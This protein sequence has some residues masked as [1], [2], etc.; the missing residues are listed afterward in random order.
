MIYSKIK[1]I[2]IALILS[3]SL[4]QKFSY[5]SSSFKESGRDI[6]NPGQ[7]FYKAVIVYFDS[8]S[9]QYSLD[10]ADQVYH[11]RCELSLYS[12]A[13]NHVSDKE[14]S[15]GA[16][17]GLD[18]L[19]SKIKSENKNA[20]IRFAYDKGLIGNTNHE[21]SM[22]TIR[23][24]IKQVSKILNKYPD[25]II[26]IE[27][28]MLGPWGEMHTSKIATE[29]NKSAVFK[30]WLESTY[31]IPVLARTPHS[32]FKYF[33][34]SLDQMEK[35]TIPSNDPGYRLGV[36]NDCYLSTDNDMGT[37]HNRPR[38]TKW[39]SK[40]NEHLPYGGEIC[41][42][43]DWSNLDKCLPE[44][45]LLKTNFINGGFNREVTEKK[46]KDK[47]KYTSSLGSDSLFYGLSGYDYIKR[48]LGYRLLIKSLSVTYNK[49]GSYSMKINLGNVGF[50]YLLQTKK[51]DIIFTDKNDKEIKRATVGTYNGKSGNLKIEFNGNFLAEGVSSEYKVYLSIYGSR[52]S[53]FVFYPVELANEN[54]Y[55]KNL[56][57]HYLFTVKNGQISGSKQSSGSSSS[58]NNN[59][60]NSNNISTDYRC[61]TKN[62]K[63]CP[64]NY[65]CS[66]YGYCGNSDDHCIKYCDPKY[67][68]CKN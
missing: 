67:G 19:L 17:N 59:N 23:T 50:G 14:I 27:S 24:H 34:K 21:P 48:H 31:E 40:Q 39:L 54:I 30:Y 68:E 15:S 12:K 51:L 5:S 63:Y 36:F 53:N 43:H 44:M 46:W 60:N 55:N 38:E 41:A 16:L 8:S 33:S 52:S 65:C 62:G 37:F 28:G 66:K 4:A 7:G 3:S 56:K 22:S 58:G 47:V 11:L 10:K 1:A 2:L 20:I 18:K 57:A 29:E 6:V 13:V 35:Y 32:I 49:Y 64:K 42:N 9:L 45:R 25:T 61:G 26:A